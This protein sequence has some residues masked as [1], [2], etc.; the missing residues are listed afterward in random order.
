MLPYWW[1]G[2]AQIDSNLNS[3]DVTKVELS[4]VLCNE[5][6][7]WSITIKETYTT[8]I[9]FSNASCQKYPSR[10][11]IWAY[12]SCIVGGIKLH[13]LGTLY[14][15]ERLSSRKARIVGGTKLHPNLHIR[16]SWSATLRVIAYLLFTDADV[17]NPSLLI[18]IPFY[19]STAGGPL[20]VT[21]IF[22]FMKR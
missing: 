13:P 16:K 8:Y 19:S 12:K 14:T 6:C 3:L 17:D 2:E 9:H 5:V 7:M 11:L 21:Y 15:T 10:R 22:S 20:I 1:L 18:R 4:C